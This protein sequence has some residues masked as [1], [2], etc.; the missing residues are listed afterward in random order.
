MD[1]ASG[2]W[3]ILRVFSGLKGIKARIPSVAPLIYFND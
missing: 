2:K 1:S 3:K